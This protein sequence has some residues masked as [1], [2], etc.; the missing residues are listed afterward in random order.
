MVT[1]LIDGLCRQFFTNPKKGKTEF[2]LFA[3]KKRT[4][5]RNI[6]VNGNDINQSNRYKYLGAPSHLNLND[7]SG[8]VQTSKFQNEVAKEG[9]T[10]DLPN[11]CSDNLQLNDPTPIVLLFSCVWSNE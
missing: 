10:Q 5:K 4:E 11:G 8:H 9:Q 1:L 2:V 6:K 3:S 7:V